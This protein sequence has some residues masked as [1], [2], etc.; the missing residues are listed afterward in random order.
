M[1][2]AITDFLAR[3]V[4][5]HGYLIIFAAALIENS[6][7]TGLV[8]PGDTI[9]VLTGF[10]AHGTGLSLPLLIVLGWIGAVAGDSLGY[11]IGRSGG[12]PL[13]GRL[14]KRFPRLE[15]HLEQ[16]QRYF[17]KHGG[18]TVLTGRFLAIVRTVMPFT[19]GVGK[20]HYPSFLVYNLIGAAIQVPAL[21][22]IGY[23]FGAQWPKI[24]HV[25]GRGGAVALVIIAVVA[26]FVYRRRRHRANAGS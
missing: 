9:L 1:L 16:S 17:K 12:R 20:M 18:K 26:F 7:F 23:F 11:L 10:Y 4:A 5:H 15:K 25:A 3:E 21:I 8:I 14:A 19:A 22:L 6:A 2:A 24:E 13:L